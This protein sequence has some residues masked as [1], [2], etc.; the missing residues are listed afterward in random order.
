[1]H[2]RMSRE[3]ASAAGCSAMA[4]DLGAAT[5]GVDSRGGSQDTDEHVYWH[6]MAR[7]G[8]TAADAA[9]GFADHIAH[10]SS[11]CA[12]EDIALVLHAWQDS[13]SPAHRGFP[14]WHGFQGTSLLGLLNHG[15][16]DFIASNGTYD[17]A[18]NKSKEIILDRM[19][20]CPNLCKSGA[21]Q[22]R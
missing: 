12:L 4:N 16:N 7:P 1:M 10:Y 20:H 13:Y 8:Q 5:A 15:L 19:S 17:A 21:Q 18:K 9:Q 22:C 3:A 2:E 6:H 11:S 14:Q